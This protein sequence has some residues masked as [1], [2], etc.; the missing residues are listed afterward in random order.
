MDSSIGSFDS[1]TLRLPLRRDLTIA[2]VLSLAIALIMAS[3]AVVSLVLPHVIYPSDE[4]IRAFMPVDG[5]HLIVGI[6]VLLVCMWCARA[7]RVAAL[8]CWPGALLYV[9]YSYVANLLGVPF[10]PLFL[11]YLVLVVGSAYTIII[12]VSRIDLIGVRRRLQDASPAVAAG[13]VLV[14]FTGL[15]IIF[16]VVQILTVLIRRSPVGGLDTMLW[17]AD[18]GTL[19]TAGLAGGILLLQRRALGYVAGTGLLLAHA[20]LFFGLV[21]VMFYPAV[22]YGETVEWIGLAMMAAAGAI[23][24]L[25][26]ALFVRA[27]RSLRKQSQQVRAQSPM[28]IV[29]DHIVLN[30][31]DE[32]RMIAFYTE[33]LPFTAERLE[34]YRDGEVPFPSVRLNADTIIDL[35]PKKLWAQDS[36]LRRGRENLN[37]FC[38]AASPEA[39]ERLRE[40]LAERSIDVVD[41]PVLRWGAHGRGTSIY[42][43]DPEGNLIEARYY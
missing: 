11:P 19:G 43:R 8:L 23:C 35:F 40:R 20:L 27:A 38:F 31:E 28:K 13:V 14:A 29:M 3:A 5:F 33:M 7:G 16:A 39:W 42:F 10:G 1:N 12:I 17:I 22:R 9:L 26:C 18:L 6:P 4:L 15:F 41:G 37:H 2:Y 24:M 21:P 36:P 30:V 34:E 25:L 32:E